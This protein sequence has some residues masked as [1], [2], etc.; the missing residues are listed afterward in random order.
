VIK[1]ARHRLRELE[2]AAKQHAASNARQLPLFG[3]ELSPPHPAIEQL[4]HINP[5][6]LTP[7]QALDVLYALKKQL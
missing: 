2:E 1:R 3:P 6:D 5:D 4:E 7:R